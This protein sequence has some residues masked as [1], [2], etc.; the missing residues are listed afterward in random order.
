[1]V[2]EASSGSQKGRIHSI[3]DQGGSHLWCGLL[4]QRFYVVVENMTHEAKKPRGNGA[5]LSLS[6]KFAQR[7]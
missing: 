3:I 5:D 2:A 1:L 6:Q 4:G 7:F